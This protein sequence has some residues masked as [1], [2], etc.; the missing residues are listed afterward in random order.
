[1]KR[2]RISRIV[3]LMLVLMMAVQSPMSVLAT[4]GDVQ[5]PIEQSTDELAEATAVAEDSAEEEYLLEEE[6]PEEEAIQEEV[7]T[8]LA[9]EAL[10]EDSA[11][12][13]GVALEEE[14]APVEEEQA[15]VEEDFA[16]EDPVAEESTTEVMTEAAAGIAFP[17]TTLTSE[18]INGLAVSVDVPEGALP[19][20]TQMSV[21]P[22]EVQAAQ[23]AVDNTDG[24]EGTVLAAA[25]IT[26]L[27]NDEE[28]QPAKEV[29]V[30]MTSD[31]LK[32]ADNTAVVHL[33][34]TAEE[35][36]EAAAAAVEEDVV[37]TAELAEAE[38]VEEVAAEEDTVT[39]AAEN[40]SV[41]AV[42]GTGETGDEARLTVNFKN[43]DTTIASMLV[44]KADTTD[45]EYD[46]VVYDPGVGELPEGQIFSGWTLTKDYTADTEVKDI[47]GI[48]TEIADYFTNNEVK[49]GDTLDVYAMIYKTY[50]VTYKEAEDGVSLSAESILMPVTQDTV[51]YTINQAYTPRTGEQ[52][53]LGWEVAEGAENISNATLEGAAVTEP[54]Q[55][56]TTITLSGDVEFVADAPNGNWL[57]FHE[58]GGTYVAPQFVE[59]GKVTQK[60][61]LDMVRLGYTF[62]GW[63]TDETYTTEFTFGNTIE[64]TDTVD[65]FAKWTAAETAYYTVLIWTQNLERDGYDFMESVNRTGTVGTTIVGTT[66]NSLVRQAGTGDNAYAVVQGRA[67]GTNV[68]ITGFHLGKIDPTDTKIDPAGT[69]VVNVYYDRTQYTLTFQDDSANVYTY[70]KSNSTNSGWYYIPDGNG[71]YTQKYL[72]RSGNHW[73]YDTGETRYVYTETTTTDY[74]TTCYGYVNNNY[75]QLS[76][77]TYYYY[78]YYTYG[79]RRGQEGTVYTGTRYTRSEERVTADYTGDVYTRN[80]GSSSHT[81]KTITAYYGEDISS[82]FPIKGENGKTYTG[83]VWDPQNS[84]IFTTGQVPSLET[85]PAENTTF[86]FQRYGTNNTS[87]FYYYLETLPGET[88]TVTYNGKQY[89][90]H[91][92]VQISI[93]DGI[94]STKSEDFYDITGFT[95]Y[96]T[97]PQYENDGKVTLSSQNNYTM[98]FYYT[99]KSY[100][101]NYMDGVYFDGNGNNI[102]EVTNRGQL[103]TSGTILYQ[104]NISSYNEGGANYYAPNYNG[105]VFAGWYI[106]D[107][108]TQ[109]YTFGKMPEGGITVY[110]KWIKVQYRVF[111]HSNADGDDSLDWGSDDQ[112]MNFR[113][114]AGD[115]VSTPTG[116]RDEYELVGWYSDEA[117]TKLFNA[118]YTV[119]NDTTVTTPYD[120]TTHMTDVMDKF[121]NGA[122]TNSDAEKNRFWLTRE[123][124]L[125][126]KWRSK[127]IGAEGI[128]VVYDA[129]EGTNAPDDDLKYLDQAEAIAQAASTAPDGYRFK[130]W[131]VQKWNGTEYEDTDVEVYPGNDFTV[132][133]ADAKEERIPGKTE[134]D[135]IYLTYTVQLR[136]EYVPVNPKNKVHI[137]WYAN[138]GIINGVTEVE[139]K[140]DVGTATFTNYNL[141]INEAADIPAATAVTRE[142]YKFVG[143]A[144]QEEPEGAFAENADD[145]ITVDESKY[146]EKTDLTLWLK[147]NDDGTW[148]ELNADGTVANADVKQVAADIIEPNHA[149]YAV[150]E[151]QYFYIYHSSD[152]TVEKIALAGNTTFDITAKVKG[153]YLYGGYYSDYARKGD[154]DIA[155]PAEYTTAV[156]NSKPYAGGAGYWKKAN[157]L[158]TVGTAMTPEVNTTYFLKEVPAGFLASKIYVIYDSHNN[159]KVVDN[160]LIA[161][162]DDSNYS[163]I[164]LI[165]KSITTGERIKLAASYTIV[166]T[167]NA[168]EDKI[169]AKDTFGMKGGYVAVWQPALATQD[170][171]LAAAYVTL[172]GVAV[173]GAF[174]RAYSVGDGTYKD[175]FE[176]GN[177]GFAITDI[178]NTNIKTPGQLST[179]KNGTLS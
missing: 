132:L 60:P 146:S 102:A 136:A 128:E 142:G 139:G 163:E 133:K 65:I 103:S 175:T 72:T 29:K 37:S 101:I 4:E 42:I 86:K 79:D 115:K 126:A 71:G 32:N 2:N 122:T 22:V 8:P 168:K 73:T 144:R 176:A 90:E 48:R 113:I 145:T 108:C 69:A 54:Y 47:A 123:L 161:D 91:Q 17:E 137:T 63:Y 82:Y 148:D 11:L 110:A 51:E 80:S 116:L 131:I 149:M 30:T 6:A 118:D 107:A 67:G 13:D 94:R 84:R 120:K 89:T 9:G 156:T 99:R 21:V 105:Y 16:E 5:V 52:N 75:V 15:D 147:L 158:T 173:E 111:L 49:E 81:I 1:M 119:L 87:H 92:H 70:T 83:Y 18:E 68:Q 40:F 127:M 135:G 53:F 164:G 151:A 96:A 171:E 45:D 88:G 44:K 114:S 157:A 25:D 140:L 100:Q 178:A 130:S 121:G 35:L 117:C 154:Y 31:E 36:E 7:A 125:Y 77:H 59:K 78:V 104:A 55:N 34:T 166:D 38:P 143:W 58:N 20:G 62:D 179:R 24:V 167:L 134:A 85:M 43:G 98:K 28:I 150:W 97:D 162:V 112:A 41:Y 27:F 76:R 57:V 174:I 26:F 165:A 93:G 106:D 124:N 170:F 109:A 14:I 172:D 23:V 169:T 138:G 39:F 19:A 56:G 74:W 155:N 141:T 66:N 64:G 12:I 95:Q 160:Y 46:K 159:N 50:S 33:D 10:L 152:N 61:S 3:S 177:G 153:D 129:G